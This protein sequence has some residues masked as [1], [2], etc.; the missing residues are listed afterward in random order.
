M[1]YV[2]SIDIWRTSNGGTSFQ[3]ITNGYSNGNVHV[4][5]QNMDFSPVNPDEMF[6]TNDGGVWKSS[7][8]GTSW[9]NLNS[10]LTLHSFTE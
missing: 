4:D 1:L 6:C 9:T 2:G 5:Q 10:T 8:R 7:D 3:N